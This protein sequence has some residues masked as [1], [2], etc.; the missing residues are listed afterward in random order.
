MNSKETR[1][2]TEYQVELG[3]DNVRKKEIEVTEVADAFTTSK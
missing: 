3:T 2:V 1:P